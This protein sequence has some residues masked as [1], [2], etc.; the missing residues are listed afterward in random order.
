M[1]IAGAD[2]WNKG[3]AS[4]IARGRQLA[5]VR[6]GSAGRIQPMALLAHTA[7]GLYCE[8]GD[9]YIDPWRPV[10]R[11]VVQ[12]ARSAHAHVL[13]LPR[14]QLIEGAVAAVAGL[15]LLLLHRR[16]VR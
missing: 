12:L 14:H 9:F 10:E 2:G 5:R 6:A 8:A 3:L 1:K 16:P 11:A 15:R 7:R 13:P 4:I